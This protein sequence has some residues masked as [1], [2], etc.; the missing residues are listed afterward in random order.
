LNNVNDISTQSPSVT[1]LESKVLLIED[2]PLL[3]TRL[4]AHLEL[5][6]RIRVAAIV[7]SACDAQSAMDAQAFDV[8]IVD[9]ELKQGSGMDAVRYARHRFGP[10]SPPLII[11]LTNYAIPA[12][13]VRC[14]QAGADYFLD[15]MR[16][17]AEVRPLIEQWR[18]KRRAS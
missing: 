12:V 15:K 14:R 1:A 16:Q 9:V 17:F 11:V 5:A 7:D 18:A 4:K 3:Q 13:E 2:S 6:G 10:S 8:L